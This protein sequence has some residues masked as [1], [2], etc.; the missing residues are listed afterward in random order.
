MFIPGD[1]R[2]ADPLKSILVASNHGLFREFHSEDSET[3]AVKRPL[4]S[5]IYNMFPG[6]EAGETCETGLRRDSDSPVAFGKILDTSIKDDGFAGGDLRA[7][8]FSGVD[9]S[10]GESPEVGDSCGGVGTGV[11]GCTLIIGTNDGESMSLVALDVH[12]K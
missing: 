5:G 6:F 1:A 12:V 9:S 4:N 10:G 11:G 2:S 3:A 7:N 8:G